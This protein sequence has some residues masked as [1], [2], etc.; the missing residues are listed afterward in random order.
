MAVLTTHDTALWLE[1]KAKAQTLSLEDRLRLCAYLVEMDRHT[2]AEALAGDVV[3]ALRA[4]R[5]G[6][7]TKK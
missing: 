5:R 7:D 6:S 3:D 4:R 2:I 1:C